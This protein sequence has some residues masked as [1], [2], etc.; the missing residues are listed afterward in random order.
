MSLTRRP[1]CARAA[2][3]AKLLEKLG[4]GLA[5]G[6][7]I[8][9]LVSHPTPF[10]NDTDREMPHRPESNFMYLTGCDVPGAAVTITLEVGKGGALVG[11]FKH[12]LY[13]ALHPCETK[14]P[15]S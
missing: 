1:F 14:A 2:D 12:T 4:P 15:W 7:H 11:D 3:T 5:P 10:R 13:V 8:V 6:R 9:L